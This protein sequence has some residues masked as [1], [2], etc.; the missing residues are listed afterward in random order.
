M[1]RLRTVLALA[2]AALVVVPAA[3]TADPTEV[4]HGVGPTVA[5]DAAYAGVKIQVH[6]RSRAGSTVV[7]L[8]ATGLP[9]DRTFGAHV[10][11][12]PCGLDPLASGGHYQH[13][14]DASVPL[15]DRE[16][17]LDI[18]SDRAGRAV[19]VTTVP[20]EFEP[21]TAGSVVL[22]AAPTDEATGA[23]GARLLC[24]SVPFGE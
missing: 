3:A 11:V 20:W 4:D 22:H 7:R 1:S 16:V 14:T 18:A 24:T 8:S 10:H 5:H 12:L 19:T 9:A 23:A 6:S 21:G 15:R 2:G 13:S 17:W